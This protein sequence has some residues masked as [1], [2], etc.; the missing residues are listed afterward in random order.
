M[1]RE[2]EP[3]ELTAPWTP[4]EGEAALAGNKRG[5]T[6]L[7]FAVFLKPARSCGANTAPVSVDALFEA[8]LCPFPLQQAKRLSTLSLAGWIRRRR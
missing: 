6:R 5:A 4:V 2:W 3:E 7:R 1:R 8:H